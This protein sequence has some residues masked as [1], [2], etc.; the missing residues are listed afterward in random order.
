M[1]FGSYSSYY[2][3]NYRSV[4]VVRLQKTYFALEKRCVQFH[5]VIQSAQLQQYQLY[6]LCVLWLL[7]VVMFVKFLTNSANIIRL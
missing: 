4:I 5:G 7:A 6:E 2:M 3:I 1:E